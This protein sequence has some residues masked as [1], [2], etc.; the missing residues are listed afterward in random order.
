MDIY[1]DSVNMRQLKEGYVVGGVFTP[2]VVT[3]NPGLVI[4]DCIKVTTNFAGSSPQGI[5]F[6]ADTFSGK[7][8]SQISESVG[9]LDQYVSQIGTAGIGSA[10][11]L[12][13]HRLNSA[14]TPNIE[15]WVSDESVTGY[16]LKYSGALES[17]DEWSIID[18]GATLV[19]SYFV[20]QFT[21]THNIDVGEIIIAQ[22]ISDI[23]R[24]GLNGTETFGN[25]PRLRGNYGG[26]EF[27]NKS[28]SMT[29]ERNLIWGCLE[30]D[31]YTKFNTLIE[32]LYGG[33]SKYCLFV[34]NGVRTYGK[35]Y[36]PIQL[37]YPGYQ[38]VSTGLQTR[39]YL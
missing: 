10:T 38:N 4:D 13:I 11:H 36:I 24:Y 3:N 29:S 16:T 1:Y 19:N 27:A 6:I 25:L 20:I 37:T 8:V 5:R 31:Q 17:G 14:N 15:V 32:G 33:N 35:I 23:I 34:E 28:K 2:G 9:N 7:R 21:G 12:L 39:S 30:Q 18:L 26:L 22:K